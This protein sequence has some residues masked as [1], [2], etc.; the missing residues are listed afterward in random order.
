MKGKREYERFRRGEPLTHKQA[1][2]AQ[3]Y[4]CNGL[5]EGGDDCKGVSCPL[6]QHMPYRAGRKKRQLS[7]AERERLAERLRKA[8]RP[9][10]LPVQDA[11]IL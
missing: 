1:I 10:K 6:Y 2:L 8:R 9:L 3:C 7:K 5:E 4:A 11:E